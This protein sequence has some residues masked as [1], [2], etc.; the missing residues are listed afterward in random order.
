[1]NKIFEKINSLMKNDLSYKEISEQLIEIYYLIGK[2]LMGKTYQD[3]YKLE[4]QLREKY[5]LT[6]GFSKRNILNMIKLMI[7]ILFYP[8]QAII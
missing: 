2:N 6:I 3:A 7:F 5:G 1:M 8:Y 4:Y